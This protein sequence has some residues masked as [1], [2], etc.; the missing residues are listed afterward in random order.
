MAQVWHPYISVPNKSLP[1]QSRKAIQGVPIMMQG[2]MHVSVL[3]T[4]AAW[5]RSKHHG[6]DVCA[7]WVTHDRYA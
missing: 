7:E 2:E 5:K 4:V 1:A 6:C 3:R